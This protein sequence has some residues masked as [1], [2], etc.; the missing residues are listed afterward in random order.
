MAS[1]FRHDEPSLYSCCQV[2][3][4]FPADI[5]LQALWY[6]LTL[7]YGHQTFLPPR[8]VTLCN[9]RFIRRLTLLEPVDLEYYFEPRYE[10]LKR[11]SCFPSDISYPGPQKLA[12]LV[13]NDRT[14]LQELVFGPARKNCIELWHW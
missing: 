7:P 4:I 5:F 9:T 11:F 13:Q 8:R 12:Q 14:T 6:D 1:Y 2:Y 3:K 10:N